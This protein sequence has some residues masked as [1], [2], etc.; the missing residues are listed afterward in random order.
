MDIIPNHDL[1]PL[2]LPDE[3]ADIEPDARKVRDAITA[4]EPGKAAD[5]TH[6]LL[7]QAIRLIAAGYP[8]PNNIAR[9]VFEATQYADGG[10][11][12]EI[13][14]TEAMIDAA[15]DTVRLHL[16]EVV[17]HTDDELW[18]TLLEHFDS[19]PLAKAIE[20]ALQAREG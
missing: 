20:A 15:R 13:E 8:H 3:I 11:Q 18:E 17:R 2:T 7:R 6:L 10:R 16:E 14:V 12:P 9:A 19:L 1:S 4:L 5:V